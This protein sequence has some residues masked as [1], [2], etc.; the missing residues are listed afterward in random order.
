MKYKFETDD[1]LFHECIAALKDD[2]RILTQDESYEIWAQFK[3]NIPL[4][5]NSAKI[6]W[7]KI[8]LK[9]S[10]ADL[11]QVIPNLTI[12]LKKTFN[13]SVYIFWNDASVPVIS[14]ELNLV[15]ANFDDVISVGFETW[16]YNP[17][18]GY[19]IEHNHSG[20]LTIGLLPP[21]K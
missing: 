15:L 19:I 18:E 13:S 4:I 21:I 10:V 16:F 14:S 11:N 6:N 8:N 9:E 5:P 12:L 3:N 20:Y 2:V 1:T 7:S 17:E